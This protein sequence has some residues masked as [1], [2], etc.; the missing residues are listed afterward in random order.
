[1]QCSRELTATCASFLEN[2]L[3]KIMC[4]HHFMWKCIDS[5][6]DVLQNFDK[7]ISDNMYMTN[8]YIN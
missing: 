6:A 3:L 4:C 7:I 8:V 1:M 5:V 2:I